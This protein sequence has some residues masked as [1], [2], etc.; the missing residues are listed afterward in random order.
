[1]AT[2]LVL[3]AGG[4]GVRF[5][6]LGRRRRPKQLLALL[7][8]QSLLAE[9][10]ARVAPLGTPARSWVITATDLAAAC[11][12]EL[13]DLPPA[14]VLGEPEGKN[15]AAAVALAALLALREDPRAILAVFPSDH[16]VADAAGLRALAR[17][18][19][20]CARED[21]AFVTL[22][23]RPTRAETG[24]GYLELT[25]PAVAG[26][27]APVSAFIEKPDAQR[28]QAFLGSG[29]HLWNSGIFFLPARRLAASFAELA[30]AIW[31]PLAALPA[32]DPASPRF[33]RA[34]RA[35]YAEL[36]AESFDVAVMERAAGVKVIAADIGWSDVGGWAALGERL[37][38]VG[39]NRVQ[40]ELVALDAKDNIVIDREGLTALLGVEGLVVVR[41]GGALLVA[42]RERLDALRELVALVAARE[43]GRHL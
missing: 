20:R 31:A 8:P 36:P 6:P 18:A 11:R 29:R 9:T 26:E 12:H 35:A 32:G 19:L 24:Y 25:A 38:A 21:D 22:G 3:L 34:L 41:S 33:K 17:R 40:G 4:R 2:W 10:W 13:P 27:P 30:P 16:V 1:M 23:L 42:R 28:A 7:S 43:G 39:G 15:T 37:P 5:W 14:R